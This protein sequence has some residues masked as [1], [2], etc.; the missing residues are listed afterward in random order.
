MKNLDESLIVLRLISMGILEET[1]AEFEAEKLEAEK[2]KQEKK[3][4][5][6]RTGISLRK[7]YQGQTSLKKQKV[8]G[9]F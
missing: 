3:S 1:I 7:I 4:Q 6:F 2:L 8:I 5:P 9:A